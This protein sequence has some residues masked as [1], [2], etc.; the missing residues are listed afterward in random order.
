MLNVNEEIMCSE[1]MLLEG[2]V[3]IH[4]LH[5]LDVYT[6]TRE[7]NVFGCFSWTYCFLEESKLLW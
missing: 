7:L 2:S 6:I 1:C 5:V 3:C 4:G